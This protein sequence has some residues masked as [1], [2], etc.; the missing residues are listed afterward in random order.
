[1]A[2]IEEMVRDSDTL[3]CDPEFP[4]DDSSL[5]INPVQPPAYASGQVEWK[6]PHEIYQGEGDPM[7]VKDGV[8]S[9]DV[10]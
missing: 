10:K 9:G 4:A 6:R 8:S 7:M 1:M 5:Y 3:Y 2:R